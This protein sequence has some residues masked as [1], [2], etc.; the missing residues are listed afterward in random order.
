MY[1]DIKAKA[2]Q[3]LVGQLPQVNK[4]SQPLNF[5]ALRPSIKG[6]NPPDSCLTA[7]DNYFTLRDHRYFDKKNKIKKMTLLQCAAIGKL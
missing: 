6:N 1:F 3:R 7:K 5:L 4:S 2:L